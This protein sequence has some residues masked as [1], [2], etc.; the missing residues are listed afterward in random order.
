MEA[1][2]LKKSARE[3]ASDPALCLDLFKEVL[4]SSCHCASKRPR[5]KSIDQEQK[6]KS[7]IQNQRRVEISTRRTFEIESTQFSDFLSIH[8]QIKVWDFIQSFNIC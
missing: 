7:K 2:R 1:T 6:R 5:A 4:Y 8:L 3:A